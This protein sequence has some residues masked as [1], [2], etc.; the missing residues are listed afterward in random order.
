MKAK[1]MVMTALVAIDEK[2]DKL[3]ENITCTHAVYEIESGSSNLW[4]EP[5]EIILDVE[6]N[7]LHGPRVQWIIEQLEKGGIPPKYTYVKETSFDISNLTEE[8]IAGRGY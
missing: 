3:D 5:G 8:I 6:C 1:I 7:P 4:M 2:G